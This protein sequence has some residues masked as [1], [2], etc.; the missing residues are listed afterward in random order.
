M[1]LFCGDGCMQ[2]LVRLFL[3][4]IGLGL[5]V[6]SSL[7]WF[8]LIWQSIMTPKYLILIKSVLFQFVQILGLLLTLGKLENGMI[9][10]SKL[11]VIYVLFHFEPCSL[12]RSNNA[13]YIYCKQ[14]WP[15][16]CTIRFTKRY[17]FFFA[18]RVSYA[19]HDNKDN[20][21]WVY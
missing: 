18:K 7:W 21:I 6:I 4:I 1:Y 3:D 14:Q 2:R 15:K 19:I 20:S 12:M 8:Y 16:Y 17:Q 5:L 13:V 9:F 11:S 10:F